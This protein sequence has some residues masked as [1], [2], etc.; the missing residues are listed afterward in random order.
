MKNPLPMRFTALLLL[1]A[2]LLSYPLMAQQRTISGRV[3]AQ[4]DNTPITG[5]N[6]VLKGTSTGAATDANGEYKLTVPEQGGALTFSFIGFATREVA[7]GTSNTLDVSLISDTKQLAELVVI[8]SR[9]SSRTKLDTPAPVDVIAVSKLAQ[10]MPQTELSQLLKQIAPSFNS[11]K[12]PGADLASHVDAVQLRNQ[13]PN[14]TLVLLNGKRRHTSSLLLVANNAGP[15]TTVDMRTIPLAAVEKVEILRDG[16]AAQYGSDAIAGVVNME[17][18]KSVGV[19]SGMYNTGFYANVGL[20]KNKDIDDFGTDGHLQQ[21]MGNYGFALGEKGGFINLTFELSKQ[22][23]TSRVPKGGYTGEVFDA[24]YLNNTRKEADGTPIITNPEA[25]ANPDNA[26]LRTDKGLQAARGLTPKSYEMING[27]SKVDNGTIFMNMGIP[28]S[29][30]GTEFYA[31]GGLNYRNTLSGCYYRF[32]RQQD[33]FLNELYP[34]GF[35]PQ[36][37]S[38]VSDKSLTVG[39]RGRAGGFDLDFSN[40]FGSSIF[41]YG[42]VNTMN[43]SYGPSTPTTMRLGDNNFTQNTTNIALSRLYSEP[44]GGVLKSMNIAFGAEMRVENYQITPGQV[45][46][47]TK[48]PY[49]TFTAPEDNFNYTQR[50]NKDVKAEKVV[51]NPDGTQT[52]TYEDLIIPYRGGTVDIKG[53]SPN[54]QCFRGFAPDQQANAFRSV[55]AAYADIEIDLTKRFM[56]GL[57]G[58]YENY[59]DFGDVLTGKLATRFSVI[60]GVFALRGSISTGFRAPSL[61]ELYYAQTSTGFTPGGVPFDQGYFTNSSTAAK[62]LGIPKLKQERSTNI[63]FGMT[64]QPASGLEVT[65]DA[66]YIKIRD[67]IIQTGGFSGSDI[68]GNL[69]SIITADGIAQFFTNAADVETKG[70][71]LVANYRTRAG[72]G[73]LTY[74]LAANWNQVAF[75]RVYP[76]NLNIGAD[77]Q[78]PTDPTLRAQYLSDIYLN[79]NSRGS[80][81]HGSPRQ[82][83]IGSIVYQ[84]GPFSAMARAIYYGAVQYYSN[85]HETED[86]TSPYADYQLGART[87]LDLSVGYQL[88]KA[89]RLSIGGDNVTN[90]YPTRTRADLTDSGRFAYDNYQM[91]FQGAYYYARLNVQF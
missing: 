3:T 15:S 73:Q 41:R 14:Q 11:L 81:E 26:A 27:L 31:F 52:T 89:V 16:A 1:I 64:S 80:F 5:V 53:Y 51:T 69:K 63:S 29:A 7:L 37:T 72:A 77:N 10:T 82:K 47:Y 76:A 57:A 75:T 91:G 8:G 62:A 55:M 34:N 88:L 32:P 28:L 2:S 13:P 38:N 61:Q 21:F 12:I 20:A 25:I 46:S 66:Y 68:G 9:N 22:G 58:R 90:T 42:M 43:A 23:S 56:I 35:L 83:Y 19:F 85:Y 18:K 60:P 87:T 44:M 54:C 4:D 65:A 39:I 59:S 86:I 17:L 36:L 71:D 84:K 74:S 48:G 33:R 6:V 79:R 67:K 50:V 70:I 45:E 24:S 78:L 40:S 49:G 30:K